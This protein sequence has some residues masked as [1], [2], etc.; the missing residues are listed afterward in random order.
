MTCQRNPAMR[1]FT[2]RNAP[3]YVLQAHDVHGLR[4]VRKK[5][6]EVTVAFAAAAGAIDTPEGRVHVRPGDALVTGHAG[7][8]WRV[9]AAQFPLR[10][11]P[12][13]PLAAGSAGRYRSRPLAAQAARMAEPFEVTLADGVSRLQ[14][15]PGEWL[16]D[17]GDGSLA[18]VSAAAFAHTYELI[19]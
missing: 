11:H 19:D 15:E 6:V 8:R 2:A 14:G 10:Y 17:Y 7:D 3:G 16:L 9:P 1:L 5:Q 4:R 13:P 12:V 18:V